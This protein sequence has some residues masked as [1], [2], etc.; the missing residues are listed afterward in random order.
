ML[1]ARGN[2]MRRSRRLRSGIA[3]GCIVAATTVVFAACGAEGNAPPGTGQAASG[4]PIVIG[5]INGEGSGVATDAQAADVR[6]A[7]EA[8][9]KYINAELGGLGGRPIKLEIC[10]TNSSPESSAGCA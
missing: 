5:F 9:V 4:E 6:E 7:T 1:R 8:A 3:R 10:I 2:R